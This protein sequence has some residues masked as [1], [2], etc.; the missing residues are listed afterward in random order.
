MTTTNAGTQ[1]GTTRRRIGT[2]NQ[3]ARRALVQRISNIWNGL[4]PVVQSQWQKYHVQMGN[5]PRSN[6]FFTFLS[7]N[8][9]IVNAGGQPISQCPQPKQ[10]PSPFPESLL[11]IAIN[12]GTFTMKI[13]GANYATPVSISGA[14]PTLSGSHI[15]KPAF[16][17]G[18]GSA[19]GLLPA[20]TAV[21]NQYVQTYWE[22][23]VGEKV[24]LKLEGVSVSGLK[25]GPYFLSE[26]VFGS[27]A[28]AALYFGIT[29]EEAA[30]PPVRVAK[31]I[32]E[33]ALHI[34]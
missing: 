34:G 3:I 10:Y 29:A 30:A 6:C 8:E 27:A 14:A 17:K 12:D 20:G 23:Q 24:G 18:I 13:M 4:G 7:A 2:D 19:Q 21:Q 32:A 5:N 16:W 15:Y 11:L 1:T 33:D 26:P 28:E 22:A 25:T 31:G 9:A